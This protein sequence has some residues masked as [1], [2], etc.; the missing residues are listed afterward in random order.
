MKIRCI[1]VDDEAPAQT[2]LQA[3]LSRLDDFELRASFSNAVEAFTYLQTHEIDLM[4]LDIQMPL[5]SGLELLKT[6]NHPPRTIITT[7][8]RDYAVEGFELNVLDYL[9]KPISFDR[10]IKAIGK[11]HQ[12]TK[13][14]REENTRNPLHDAY[15]FLK[16]D[17]QQVKVMLNDILYI[18]SIKDYLKVVTEKRMF[19][20][21]HR[22]STME[23]KLPSNYFT[24]IHK[25][26]IVATNKITSY[27][28]DKVT[29]G[30]REL[31]VGRMYRKEL[32]IKDIE[33]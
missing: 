30:G 6:L 2:L 19:V 29:V 3:Y 5:M 11:Y 10:F 14:M 18:E 8:F 28:N 12:Q 1:I 9:V 32:R 20:I 17:K 22:L 31:P 25:S 24:R 16:V 15:M 23:D 13:V 21:Y 33:S 27:R 7:A 26:F 4:L